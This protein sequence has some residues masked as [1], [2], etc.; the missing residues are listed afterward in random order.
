LVVAALAVLGVLAFNSD[1]F[2]R[3]SYAVPDLTGLPVAEAQ[4]TIAPYEWE[5]DVQS[6]RSDEQP[7]VPRVSSS[8]RVS[9]S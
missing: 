7:V 4:N 8:P 6:E 1:I 5:V 2:Q 9:R 3:P